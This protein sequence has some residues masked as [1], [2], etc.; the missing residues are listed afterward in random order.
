[1]DDERTRRELDDRVRTAFT[2]DDVRVRRI[3]QRAL[4]DDSALRG[5]GWLLRCGVVAAVLLIALLA[6]VRYR[7]HE[8]IAT[9]PASL[10]VVGRS[11][12]VIVESADGRRWLLGPAPEQRAGG[13]Y[14]IVLTE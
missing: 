11:S 7:R 14:V 8:P 12:T 6:S 9:S 4:S 2:P 5:R 3:V 1:M 13:N 10:S